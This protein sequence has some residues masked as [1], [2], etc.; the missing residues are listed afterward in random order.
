MATPYSQTTN[1]LAHALR[2]AVRGDVRFDTMSRWLYST[3]ASS[4]QVLPVGVVLPRDADDI[5]AVVQTVGQYG[6]S[7]VPRGGGTSLSGQ[8][9]GSGVVVDL[10]RYV[11]N[12][13]ELNVDAK[14]VRVQAGMNLDL[15][16]NRLRPHGL[17][18]GPDPAS[19]AA[20][21]LGGM[22]G[23]NSTGAHSIVYGMMADHVSE[24]DVVL[25]DGSQV[26]FGPKTPD[27]VAALVSR[28][29]LEG[30]LYRDIPALVRNYENDIT[31]R[32]PKTWRNV[33]GYNLNRMAGILARGESLNLGPLIVGSEGTLGIITAVKLR[34]V[35]RPKMSRLALLHYDDLRAALADV[36]HILEHQPSAIELIDRY[37]N[38]LTRKSPEYGAR[39]TFIDGDP[40]AVLIV[41]F[42][43]NSETELA[44]H[45]SKLEAA[46]RSRGFGGVI[47]HQTTIAQV[48]NVW[49]VRKAGLGLLMSMRGDAKP[50]AFV[51]DAA[52]PVD[53]LADYALEVERICIEVGTTA[54]FYAHASAG[55]LHI[56]P[57]I[58]LK[59]GDGLRQMQQISEAVAELAIRYGG[60]TTGEHGEGM[61]RSHYNEKLYGARL[62]QAF[63]Q[64]KGLFDV[65]NLFNPGKII[66]APA[67]WQPDI[68][69]F[70]PDY[71]TSYTLNDTLLDFSADGG[72]GGM[73]EMCNGQGTCRKRDAGVMCPSFIA[74][75]DEAHSTRGRANALRAV[76]AGKLGTDGLA[77][78]E[79]YEV[80][81]LCLEC[82][83]C[84]RECPSLVDMAKLKYE[85]LTHYQAVHGVSLRSRLFAHIA[86]LNRLGSVFPALTNWGFRSR[87]VRAALDRWLGIDQRR[88]LPSIAAT[89]FQQWFNR[90]EKSPTGDLGTVILWDDTYLSYNEPEIGQATVAILEAAGFEVRLIAERRCCGR[91]MISKG[92]LKE[93]RENARHNVALLAPLAAE[94]I[95]L[96]GV[97]PSCVAAFRDEYPDLLRT[98]EAR[99]VARQTF[100]IE[101]FLATLVKKGELNLSFEEDYQHILVHGHCYQKALIGTAALHTVLN[102]LPN[103]IVEEIPS[104]CCGMA[105]SFGY[106]GEHYAVSMACGEDRL[107]P[108]VRAAGTTTTIVASGTSCRHQIGD[109]TQRTAIHPVVT[110]AQR[111]KR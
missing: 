77:S 80:L 5:S 38:H 16:N 57:L 109:G 56:N 91:P 3:D 87:V 70:N 33:A 1:E 88:T 78:Q 82:K 86:A 29:T 66:D 34:L 18:V 14:W 85:F 69:R 13:I 110:V 98:D 76:M 4:Y 17:M 73:V 103:T 79:L 75:R 6:A 28:D 111:L 39:L 67:P 61:A 59:S 50:L 90:R 15:L 46:M 48:A 41:E 27:E 65:N 102:Q 26:R 84:K 35:E 24:V 99:L 23:N 96:I 81:D 63:R 7:I 10:S 32:Y 94:G 54:A 92:L 30:K 19:S 107:F 62:H 93:G 58:N 37:F 55:C 95:P 71:R 31:T 60:T 52:V 22:T 83:A 45:A 100:F 64:V 105:G 36:P 20:A 97:E 108:A 101:E 49:A 2:G 42:A 68:L 74:T 21:T 47:V 72:F 11:D 53:T 51:D 106:E 25:A 89:T 43:G 40:R 44:D 12:V 8:T 9:I 104:G